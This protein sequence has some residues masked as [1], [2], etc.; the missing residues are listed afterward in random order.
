MSSAFSFKNSNYFILGGGRTGVATARAILKGGGKICIWEDNETARDA[1]IKQDFFVKPYQNELTSEYSGVILSP[2]IAQTHPICAQAREI[3]VP[4]IGDPELFYLFHKNN[5]NVKF[6]A[7]TGTNGKSTVTALTAHLL[8]QSGITAYAG[9]NIGKAVFD[10]PEPKPNEVTA[11][12]LEISSYQADLLDQ[13]TPHAAIFLNLTPD[14][15]ERHGTMEN[16]FQAKKNIFKNLHKTSGTAIIAEQDSY[17]TRLK[18]ELEKECVNVIS[19]PKNETSEKAKALQNATTKNPFLTGEHNF[20]NAEAAFYC[21]E[22]FTNETKKM[23]AG[24]ENYV[25]LPH[26]NEFVANVNGVSYFNDSKATNAVS[27]EK[28]LSAHQN[29]YWLAGGEAKSDG[30]D[31]FTAK[32]LQNVRFA[33]VYGKAADRFYESL[34]KLNLPVGRFKD[35]QE[36]FEAARKTAE[37]GAGNVVLLSPAC[38]SFDAFKDYEHRG[39]VFK[40]LVANL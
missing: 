21:A 35:L 31:S 23:I 12:V 13:F 14:H 22:I 30:I 19:V 28:A 7:I 20:I 25:G 6:I 10:L 1:L 24:V 40:T 2:G 34:Q 27:A 3:S 37:Q 4:I 33:Y 16:Y 26:R 15:L 38:A 8:N 17:T 29:I 18:A 36:A 32:T 11:Y 39:N 9:G 5:P